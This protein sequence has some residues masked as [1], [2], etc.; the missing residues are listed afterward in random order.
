MFNENIILFSP[1]PFFPQENIPGHAANNFNL[2]F[3]IQTGDPQT[4]SHAAQEQ[5]TKLNN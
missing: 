1:L 3:F 4:V 5:K 2:W